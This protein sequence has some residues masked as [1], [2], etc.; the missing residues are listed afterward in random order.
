MKAFDLNFARAARIFDLNFIRTWRKPARP[1]DKILSGEKLL[2]GDEILNGGEIWSDSKILNGSEILRDCE[3]SSGSGILNEISR[4]GIR[5]GFCRWILRELRG[6]ASSPRLR[7]KFQS[8]SGSQTDY[9]FKNATTLQTDRK[10]KMAVSLRVACK[11]KTTMQEFH[12]GSSAVAGLL[13]QKS[14]SEAVLRNCL[15]FQS[16]PYVLARLKFQSAMSKM[17][18]GSPSVPLKFQISVAALARLKFGG[19]PRAAEHCKIRARGQG[20]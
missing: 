13:R 2:R 19:S 9:K 10:F 15:K 1:R 5:R 20:G 11:F 6:E 4:G 12:R 3:I 18:A 16:S 8:A 7:R 14:S 17:G